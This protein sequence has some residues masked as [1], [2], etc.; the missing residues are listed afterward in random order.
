MHSM[1]EKFEFQNNNS[2][3]IFQN[4]EIYGRFGAIKQ[5]LKLNFGAYYGNFY[6]QLDDNRGNAH[7]I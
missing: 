5:Q 7:I 2:H 1:Y 3:H 6:N 4:S